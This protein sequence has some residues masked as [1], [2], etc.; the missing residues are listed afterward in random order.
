MKAGQRHVS[1]TSTK[2]IRDTHEA[3]GPH[4][5]LPW[6]DFLRGRLRL[7]F[8]FSQSLGH[9]A[10]LSHSPNLSFRAMQR[11]ISLR[12]VGRVS[13]GVQA[14]RESAAEYDG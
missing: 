1:P 4:G 14:R 10:L 11:E 12:F 6:L 13:K 5:V 8:C 2:L 7:Q 3:V 9:S